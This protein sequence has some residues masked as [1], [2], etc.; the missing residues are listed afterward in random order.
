[1]ESNEPVYFN[2]QL[3]RGGISNSLLKNRAFLY[4]DGLFET[5]IIS[6]GSL[7]LLH[8]HIERIKEG[9]TILGIPHQEAHTAQ[10]I[11]DR[12]LALKKEAKIE[13]DARIRWQVWREGSGR[14][15]PIDPVVNDLLT[16]EPFKYEIRIKEKVKT[17]KKIQ[18]HHHALSHLK[19]ISALPYVMAGLEN[20]ALR[21]DDLILTDNFGHIA[22]LTASNIWWRKNDQYYTPS[23]ETG[24]IKGVIR[25]YLM[26]SLSNK[27]VQIKT[28]KYP[29]QDLLAAD[30]A[31]S[32]NAT[33]IQPIHQI[34]GHILEIS[35][36]EF[37]DITSKI[38]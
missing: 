28:G 9:M 15:T 23:L 2:Y 16:I 3:I 36:D 5:M 17:S 38:F 33:G 12:C 25:T 35:E 24:C 14:Y 22:E 10:I 1:M 30:A 34:E 4:G 29:L 19:T 27:G 37:K 32:L 7:P 31:W 20:Q 13:G 11:T 8:Y 21:T 6:N 26:Q 18:L